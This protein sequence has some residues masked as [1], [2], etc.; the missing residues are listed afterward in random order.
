MQHHFVAAI[1]PAAG[2]PYLY[3]VKV[4]QQDYLLRVVGPARAV[5]AGGRTEFGETLFVGP[6]LQQQLKAAG[7]KLE[8]TTDYGVSGPGEAAL[9]IDPTPVHIRRQLWSRDIS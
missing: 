4:D 7:P 2:L 3:D 8:L 1:V 6:K 9:R 5:P